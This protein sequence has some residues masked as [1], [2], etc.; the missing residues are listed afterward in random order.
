V[1]MSLLRSWQPPS[2]HWAFKNK[3]ERSCTSCR[4]SHLMSKWISRV[5]SKS[6]ASTETASQS[7]AF[8][9]CSKSL[10]KTI[11]VPLVFRSSLKFVRALENVSL[12]LRSS[13][14]SNTQIRIVTVASTSKSSL[15]LSQ[16]NTLKYDHHLS[17]I[18]CS[19]YQNSKGRVLLDLMG[20]IIGCLFLN[21]TMWD[22]RGLF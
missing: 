4:L 9:N 18:I 16:N 21:I 7:Q 19:N 10:T 3:Q 13:K 8:S 6:S 11:K 1:A 2:R 20:T 12:L 15:R 22:E 5:F 14:W 17:S